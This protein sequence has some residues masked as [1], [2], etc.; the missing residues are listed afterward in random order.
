MPDSTVTP[1]VVNRAVDR[2]IAAP[3]TG[4]AQVAME[5]GASPSNLRRLFHEH[6][7][8]SV[9][10]FLRQTRINRAR[11]YLATSER[12]ISEIG[13]LCGYAS[14]YSFSRSFRQAVGESPTLYRDHVL[15]GDGR[16][17]IQLPN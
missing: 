14:I 13:E 15:R 11:Y 12:S 7:N 2:I 10:E 8:C 16:G 1:A 17:K 4:A 6:L 5:A 3:G 9:G